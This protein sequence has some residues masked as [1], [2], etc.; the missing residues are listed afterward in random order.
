MKIIKKTEGGFA[1]NENQFNFE[2]ANVKPY[3]IISNLSLRT[4]NFLINK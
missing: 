3:N 2:K 1:K 4:H